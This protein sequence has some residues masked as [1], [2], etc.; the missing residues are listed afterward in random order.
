MKLMKSVL[1]G[2]SALLLATGAAFAGQD[3]AMH[4]SMEMSAGSESFASTMPSEIS[5]EDGDRQYFVG[6]E[7]DVIYLYPIEVTE[8]YLIIPQSPELG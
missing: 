2:I 7:S 8:Y 5:M 1:C 4:G 3:S 6:P